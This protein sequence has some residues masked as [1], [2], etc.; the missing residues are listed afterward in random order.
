MSGDLQIISGPTG[1][2]V[3]DSECGTEV[4]SHDEVAH[5]AYG[6][7]VVL[8]LNSRSGSVLGYFNATRNAPEQ[9]M[10][11]Y[12]STESGT[13]LLSNFKRTLEEELEAVGWPMLRDAGSKQEFYNHLGTV[14]AVEPDPS[15]DRLIESVRESDDTDSLQFGVPD[16]RTAAQLV[17]RIHSLADAPEIV[18]TGAYVPEALDDTLVKIFIGESDH[19]V[20]PVRETK[21][22][23]ER[24][25]LRRAVQDVQEAASKLDSVAKS[26]EVDASQEE[27]LRAL[28]EAKIESVGLVPASPAVRD[29]ETSIGSWSIATGV[30]GS[31][32]AAV[33]VAAL[34]LPSLQA[35]MTT[36]FVLRV[37][38]L[39]TRLGTVPSW[40]LL[41]PPL[42]VALGLGGWRFLQW[43]ITTFTSG[44]PEPLHTDL[45]NA[46]QD[47]V[48]ELR[49]LEQEPKV[50][51]DQD[52]KQRGVEGFEP[53]GRVHVTLAEFQQQSTK[54][55]TAIGLLVGALAAG[56]V[57]VLLW[58]VRPVVFENWRTVTNV[59]LIL[60]QAGVLSASVF[61]AFTVSRRVLNGGLRA[62][63][64]GRSSDTSDQQQPT[65]SNDSQ[66]AQETTT[67]NERSTDQATNQGQAEAQAQHTSEARCYRDST[68]GSRDSRNERSERGQTER[69]NQVTHRRSRANR[70]RSSAKRRFVLLLLLVVLAF[71]FLVAVYVIP[72]F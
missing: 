12:E 35:A 49:S 11:R 24:D 41:A 16:R 54:V 66:S 7:G 39:D 45:F 31:F 36:E 27:I 68:G 37:A 33:V 10:A 8:Y 51:S 71:I 55:Q 2:L 29:S 44:A 23:Y 65:P 34:S 60:T 28:T 22:A 52:L 3:Y 5:E 63:R 58:S 17:E 20:A 30:V 57:G 26:A 46:A 19:G 48:D 64:G 9:F 62:V 15:V 47:I 72:T 67:T 13:A 53:L 1:D 42:V 6:D 43:A 70:K 61:A 14:D 38:Y 32:V 40:Q 18:V 25:S 50:E 59:V 21:E 56:A 69:T 4:D